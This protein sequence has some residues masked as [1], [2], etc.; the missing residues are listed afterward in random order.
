MR[1]ATYPQLSFTAPFTDHFLYNELCEIDRLLDANPQVVALAHEDLVRDIDPA[2][3]RPGMTSE[4]VLRILVLMQTQQHTYDELSFHLNDSPVYRWFCRLDCSQQVKKS[5]MQ[6][7]I[8]K[9]RSETLEAISGHIVR[10]AMSQ[11][12]EKCRK[13]RTD[14]TG[15]ETT[16]HTPSDSSLLYDS[17]RVLTRLLK[18]AHRCVP[19]I[20]SSD[21]CRRAKRRMVGIQ[22]ARHNSRRE[23]LYIDLL[24]VTRKTVGYAERA[25]ASLNEEKSDKAKNL[26]IKLLHYIALAKQ[27]ISQTQ[28]RV[29][30]RESVPAAEKVVSIFEPHSDIIVKDGRE[31]LYGHKVCLT[32][33][34]SGLIIDGKILD[35]NP[36]D[37]TLAVEMIDRLRDTYD[38][39]PRQA[40]FD[41]AFCSKDNLAAL[42]SI[43]VHDVAFS[44]RRGIE[45]EDMAKSKRVYK[46]LRNF[47]AGIEA[48][49]SF[50]KRKFALGCCTWRGLASF[51]SYVWSSI[52]AA[53]L[54]LLARQA[55]A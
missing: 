45:I 42:K 9:L 38:K 30:D 48:T 40:T 43:G 10:Y 51:Q 15:V 46:R 19:S 49:I 33:G 47:R 13:V 29:L 31:T 22:Y 27:V 8:K 28:R 6:R 25:V 55:T 14:C 37:S 18:E 35:G 12:I 21:H 36:A 44:K 24:K 54:V 26:S 7:N 5:S 23:P 17:V 4:Q 53:N 1:R 39:V 20:Q 41:G 34:A 50:L 11:G 3:G 32:S 52:L 2:K 16:I